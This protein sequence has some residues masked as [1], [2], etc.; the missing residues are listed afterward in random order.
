M[1]KNIKALFLVLI[2]IVSCFIILKLGYNY[3]LSPVSSEL[4]TIEVEIKNG[5][6][7]K[8]ASN[9]LKENN[10]IRNE[11]VF[12]FYAKMNSLE[13]IKSGRYSLS[14]SQDVNDILTLLNKGS[15]PVG[16]KITIPEGYEVR[17]IL[18]KLNES[19]AIDSDKFLE[20]INSP[21][22]FVDD[23][24]FL[25]DAKIVSLEGYLFPDTYYISEDLDEEGII[26]LFLDRFNQMYLENDIENI[27]NQKNISINEFITMASIVER[28]AVKQEERA[29]I[30]GVFYNRL[31][32][33]MPL[34][35]CA[36]VQ[37]I[38]KERKPVLS[39]VDTKVES[40]YNTYMNKGLPPSPIASPGLD[41]ILATLNPNQTD[42]IYFVA[43]GDGGHEF[44]KTYEEH[45]K[46]KKKYL[47]E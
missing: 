33:N 7:L 18:D 38:L 47:G 5:T 42:Y 40:P 45:L 46:A 37:Y 28:E 44:S 27:I 39:I 23:Y 31:K 3:F 20:Y 25:Q 35:S 8:E 36:T 32:I 12:L 22:S 1:S 30:A 15:R 14:Q 16:I 29:T 34:Q 11:D 26:K 19:L 21:E 10:L 9:K 17:N 24:S 41:A 6:T 2:L 13:N 43:R 4:D